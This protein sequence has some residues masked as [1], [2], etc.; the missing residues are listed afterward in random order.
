MIKIIFTNMQDLNDTIK[1]IQ[2]SAL[3]DYFRIKH[4]K[5]KKALKIKW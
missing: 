1:R 4:I 2:K 3:D 5:R